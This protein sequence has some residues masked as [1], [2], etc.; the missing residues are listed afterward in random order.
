MCVCVCVRVIVI[1]CVCVRARTRMS[2]CM[3]VCARVRMSRYVC[4]LQGILCRHYISAYIETFMSIH[5][6]YYVSNFFNG[7]SAEDDFH[8]F[9]SIPWPS[10]S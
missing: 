4:G 9:H 5:T 1:V 2:V 3:R 7:N 6:L 8:P 10:R